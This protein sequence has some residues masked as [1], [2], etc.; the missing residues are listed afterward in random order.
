MREG[1]E[2]KVNETKKGYRKDGNVNGNKK[3]FYG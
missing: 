1:E 3:T 2:D